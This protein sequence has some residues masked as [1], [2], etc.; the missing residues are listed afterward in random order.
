MTKR[1]MRGFAFGVL[2]S[3]AVI[4]YFFYQI[5][6]PSVQIKKQTLSETSVDGYLNDHQLVAVNQD[7]FNKWQASQQKEKDATK[8]KKDQA[9][10]KQKASDKAKKDVYTTVLNISSGMTTKDVADQLLDNHIIKD[11]DPFYKYLNQHHLEEYMQI[12]KFK[13][14]SDMSIPEILKIITNNK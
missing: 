7:Q 6:Q 11:K 2:L 3:C 9:A 10:E 14:S 8:T 4:A 13:L 5:Y 1:G 12:G